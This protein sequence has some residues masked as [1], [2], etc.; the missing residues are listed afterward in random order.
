MKENKLLY[1]VTKGIYS[2]LLKIIY[3]PKIE[4]LENIPSEGAIIFAGNHMH[5]YD[6]LV[7]MSHT[8]RYIHFFSK[9]EIFKGFM[10]KIYEEIG[11]ISVDREKT[12][13]VA[14]LGAMK[15]L[16]RG[17][18]IGIFPDDDFINTVNKFWFKGTLYC[19]IISFSLNF[20]ILFKSKF[21]SKV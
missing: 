6:P 18:T 12:N 1:S 3:N 10:G 17:G 19:F 16:K 13:P 5:A 8:K 2:F 11:L 15:L 14:M 9:K 21:R 4:G 7:V 20:F